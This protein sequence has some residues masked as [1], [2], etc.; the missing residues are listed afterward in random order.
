[1]T[2]SSAFE[3]LMAY[4]QEDRGAKRNEE[5]KRKYKKA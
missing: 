2:T 4:Q 3:T 5:L 1:M